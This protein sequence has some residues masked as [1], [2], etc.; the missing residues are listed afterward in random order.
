MPRLAFIIGGMQKGGTTAL[1]R[2]LA[3]HPDVQLPAVKEA[4]V[5]DAP[6][7]DDGATAEAVDARFAAHFDGRVPA[8]CLG[9]ATPITVFDP[10]FVERAWRYS[11]GL[12]WIVILRDPVD[13]AVSQWAMERAR[14]TESLP[15]WAALLMEPI[16]RR[17]HRGDWSW[18]SPLR[19]ASY[20]ARSDY[21]PQLQALR[22]R[23]P[24]EQVL[25]L[26]TDQLSSDPEGTVQSAWRFLGLPPGPVG[27][28]YPRVFEGDYRPPSRGSPARAFLRWR[29][30]DAVRR[31]RRS[32]GLEAWVE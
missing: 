10:R 18:Q 13:R 19:W 4:H 32:G 14:G 20:A 26:R 1:A 11:P 7:F 8:P 30:R 21:A 16:R 9:D 24:P 23:F 25:L 2:Y 6:D 27:L 5:F 3:R 28:P 15:L 22:R 29:L 12:R 31:W 17:R